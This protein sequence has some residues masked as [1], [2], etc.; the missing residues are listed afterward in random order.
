MFI[1]VGI[2]HASENTFRSDR[3]HERNVALRMEQ[4]EGEIL[5]ASRQLPAPHSGSHWPARLLWAAIIVTCSA[6]ALALWGAFLG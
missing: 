6:M 1:A 4:L 5:L 2:A 3:L